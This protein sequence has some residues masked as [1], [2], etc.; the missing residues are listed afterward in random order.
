VF[1]YIVLQHVPKAV[2]ERYVAESFRV[3]RRGGHVVFQVPENPAG[4]PHV[5]PPDSDTFS[6]RFF[7]EEEVTRVLL[8]RRF[9]LVRVDRYEISQASP[10]FNHMRIV[11]R[12]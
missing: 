5:E 11:A 2:S 9:S 4:A 7:S 3:L 8:R 12:K 10:P 6:L 1:S